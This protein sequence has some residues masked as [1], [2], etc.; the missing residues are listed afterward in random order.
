MNEK[1][2]LGGSPPAY[3]QGFRTTFASLSL[4]EGDKIRMLGFPK[5][6][7]ET[8]KQVIANTWS[9]GVQRVQDYYGSYEIKMVGYPWNAT[10][11]DAVTS[12]Q[13]MSRILA[14]LFAAGWVLNLSTDVTK[15]TSDLDTLLF[16]H[17]DPAPVPCEWLAISFSNGDQ[18]RFLW[19]HRKYAKDPV[20]A[21]YISAIGKAVQSHQPHKLPG[22]YEVKMNG[23]PWRARHGESIHARGL[24]LSLLSTLEQYGWTVYASV[25]QKKQRQSENSTSGDTD[26]WHC[27]RRV[28]W[29]PGMPVFHN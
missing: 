22:C 10:H 12:R 15:L 17:Q 23:Y 7:C 18:I 5:Q 8:V 25:D 2:R 26:T 20:V 29:E 21:A 6:I 11:S 14:A 28:G 19:D 27:C 16:R 13:L 4:H 9:G 3:T 24:L 1:T